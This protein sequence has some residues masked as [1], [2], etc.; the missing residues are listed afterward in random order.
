MAQVGSAPRPE[1]GWWNAWPLHVN[2][3]LLL[4]RL[5]VGALFVGHGTQKLFGWFGGDGIAGAVETMTKIGVQPA[6]F[7]AYLEATTEAVAGLMLAAGLLV[8]VAAAA[9]IG[10]MVVAIVRV[11]APKAFWSQFGGWEYNL[12]LIALLVALGVV[13]SGRYALD[14]YL[15]LALPRPWTFAAALIVTGGLIALALFGLP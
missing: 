3:A 15:P 1:S 10:D 8:P 12:V 9:L 13:G 5:V 2:K 14:R 11:H 6:P 4:V 7:W